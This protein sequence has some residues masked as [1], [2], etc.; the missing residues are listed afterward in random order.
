MRQMII[1]ELANM[2]ITLFV[3]EKLQGA[4]SGFDWCN[5][6][7]LVP[8]VTKTKEMVIGFQTTS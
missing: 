4:I 1:S 5:T 7:R 8:N 2:L 6:N 3:D